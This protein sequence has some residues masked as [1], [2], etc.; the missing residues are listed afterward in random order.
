ML[1]ISQPGKAG[2]NFTL[3]LEGRLVGPWVGELRLVCVSLLVNDRVVQL[4]LSDVSYADAQGVEL[5]N[6]L[7]TRGVTLANGSP[8]LTEQLKSGTYN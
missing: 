7:K 6:N 3:I 5:L 2:Q 8:F 1:K 4:D